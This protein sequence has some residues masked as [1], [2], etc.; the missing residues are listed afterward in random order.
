MHLSCLQ[1]AKNP[2]TS[3]LAL[4]GSGIPAGLAAHCRLRM[5]VR[6][7]TLQDSPCQR[8]PEPKAPGGREGGR[9]G[10][11]CQRGDTRRHARPL[12][13][14]AQTPSL[15]SPPHSPG[16][17]AGTCAGL[18]AE[19]AQ[20]SLRWARS[21][22]LGVSKG[23]ASAYPTLGEGH[24]SSSLGQCTWGRGKGPLARAREQRNQPPLPHTPGTKAGPRAA[25]HRLAPLLG[26]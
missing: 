22:G 24:T 17:K 26:W 16:A 15:L 5:P 23:G 19:S 10:H 1:R 8:Q 7:G 14:G 2:E 9:E 13:G 25:G 11:R 18:E 4:R 21:Q 6:C 12:L 20:P 3:T